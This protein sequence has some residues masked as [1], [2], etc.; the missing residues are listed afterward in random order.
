[1]LKTTVYHLGS[2]LEYRG[3]R[4]WRL[5]QVGYSRV[6]VRCAA[7]FSGWIQV[8]FWCTRRGLIRV[9]EGFGTG[10]GHKMLSIETLGL[11]A[12]LGKC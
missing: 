6:R 8:L 9:I 10:G 2:D 11:L 5:G 7:M 3:F 4:A 1:M 12:H